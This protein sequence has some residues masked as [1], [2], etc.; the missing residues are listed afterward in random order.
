[1]NNELVS[2]IIPSYKRSEMLPRAVKSVLAQTYKNIEVIVVDDND[3]DSLWRRDTEKIMSQFKNNHQVKYICHEK[4]KNGSVARNTGIKN[5]SGSIIAFLDDDDEYLPTKI[6]KQVSFLLEHPEY[7]AVYSGWIRANKKIIPTHQGDLSYD[8]LSGNNIIYTNVIMMWKKCAEEFGGWDESFNR[9]QEA[10]FLL[11][12]FDAGYKIGV[13]S[14]ALVLFDIT[15]RSNVAANSIVN[16]KQMMQ[17]IN[18]YTKAMD[19][20]E[21]TKKGSRKRIICSRKKGI[22][23]SYLKVKKYK[24]A[25][26]VLFE[27]LGQYPGCFCLTML[28]YGIKRISGKNY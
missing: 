7:R 14:E 2:V 19:R 3:P 27:M 12:Y 26:E 5:A 1:M 20:C 10:A 18:S 28:K 4:N 11:R 13:V 6:E 17:L 16:A 8:I 9:N 22:L 25:T 23:L 24:E 21:R 15:D